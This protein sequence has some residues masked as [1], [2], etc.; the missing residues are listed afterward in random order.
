MKIRE[1]TEKEELCLKLCKG[2]LAPGLLAR[3]CYYTGKC[4]IQTKKEGLNEA[5]KE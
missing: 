5:E 3:D 2:A 4:E 1:L